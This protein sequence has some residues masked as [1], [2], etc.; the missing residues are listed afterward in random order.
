MPTKAKGKTPTSKKQ[1]ATKSSGD[2]K[3]KPWEAAG[4][5]K[6]KAGKGS[7]PG[8]VDAPKPKKAAAKKSSAKKG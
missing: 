8:T 4:K 2:A 6:K 1:P 3:S 7:K 5:S